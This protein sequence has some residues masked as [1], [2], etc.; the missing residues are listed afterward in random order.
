MEYFGAFPAQNER[1]R[2]ESGTPSAIAGIFKAPMDILAD[3]LRGYLGLVEDLFERRDK[4]VAACEALMPHLL[5]VAADR[6]IE[7]DPRRQRVIDAVRAA[8]GFVIV[9]HPN[10]EEHFDHC[11]LARL[12][13]WQ[14][15]VGM[16]IYNG[17]I[18]RLHGSPYATNKWDMLLA[19]G[20]RVWGFANDDSHLAADD[21]ELGWN[22]AYVTEPTPAGVAAALSAGR[23]YGSTGVEITDI[24]V[25]GRRI[26]IETR[27]ARRIVVKI[28]SSSI[29]DWTSVARRRSSLTP[30]ASNASR[31]AVGSWPCRADTS[32]MHGP[33]ISACARVRVS[34]AASALA[35]MCSLPSCA[36]VCPNWLPNCVIC[37]SRSSRVRSAAG[38][39]SPTAGAI[40]TACVASPAAT[41]AAQGANRC[42]G[43]FWPR[44]AA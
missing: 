8:G 10:W 4:V 28:G 36:R 23:F 37:I 12:R 11:P 27:D 43:R 5:H 21:G 7:P 2:R 44:C 17:T 41:L 3:K 25:D 18:G 24:R 42:P 38:L 32:R 19:D 39:P 1:L 16:E 33:T 35:R 31:S 15:Y 14:G 9:N 26:R 29:T 34:C 30:A 6:R 40:L 13:E 20:R 22:G